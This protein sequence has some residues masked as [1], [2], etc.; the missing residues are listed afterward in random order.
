MA[1]SFA[2]KRAEARTR[3][4]ASKWE[5]SKAKRLGTRSKEQWEKYKENLLN[6]YK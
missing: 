6:S 1:K 2:V 3:L 5:N 4:E